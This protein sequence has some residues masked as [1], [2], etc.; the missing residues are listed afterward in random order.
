MENGDQIK[1][2]TIILNSI[3]PIGMRGHRYRG[4]DLTP[5][6]KN[7][8]TPGPNRVKDTRNKK[9]KNKKYLDNFCH[10]DDYII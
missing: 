7:V 6:L 10:I 9:N 2:L 5:V 8:E 1:T 3:N 4:M